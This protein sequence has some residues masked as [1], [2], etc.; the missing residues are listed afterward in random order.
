MA[1]CI[2]YTSEVFT[3]PPG[4]VLLVT[5]VVKGIESTKVRRTHINICGP[6]TMKRDSEYSSCV[7]NFDGK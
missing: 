4:P 2:I 7:K 1:S 6:V 3:S 5:G